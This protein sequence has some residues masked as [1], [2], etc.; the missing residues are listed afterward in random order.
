MVDLRSSEIRSWSQLWDALAGP[1]GLPTWFGRNLDA[2][3][4]TIQTGAISAIL[5]DHSSVTIILTGRGLFA[6]GAEGERFV[7]TT[8]ECDYAQAQVDYA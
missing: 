5:D 6:R 1:C 7:Q 4:D 8:N 3:W 2:W